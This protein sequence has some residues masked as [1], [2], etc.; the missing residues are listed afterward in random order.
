MKKGVF[1]SKIN[2]PLSKKDSSPSF[3]A[4]YS[5][6]E[7]SRIREAVIEAKGNLGW[8]TFSDAL[9]QHWGQ[10]DLFT[11]SKLRRLAKFGIEAE[12]SGILLTLLPFL[13]PFSQY[14]EEELKAIAL[15][16]GTVVMFEALSAKQLRVLSGVFRESCIKR[17]YRDRPVDCVRAEGVAEYSPT[18]LRGVYE[19]RLGEQLT[20]AGWDAIAAVSYRPS[21]GTAE[22]PALSNEV[23]G[24][25]EALRR[26]IKNVNGSKT[27][28]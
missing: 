5:E 25:G 3:T 22:A 1:Y 27:L 6:A 2:R 14:S 20:A 17:G 7:L 28:A 23:F 8:R 4:L 21:G 15:G 26:Y 24:S 19:G 10:P 11:P 9:N 12:A 13:A 16:K 18:T